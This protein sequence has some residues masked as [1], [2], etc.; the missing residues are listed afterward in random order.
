MTLRDLE[1]EKMKKQLDDV[2]ELRTK[3]KQM[4]D[5]MDNFKK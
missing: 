3:M 5:F 1:F 2:D 4:Q